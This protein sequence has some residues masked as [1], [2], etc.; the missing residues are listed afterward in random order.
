MKILTL[1]STSYPIASDGSEA[2]GSFVADLVLTLA[3]HVMVRV[4]APGPQTN[5]EVVNERVTVYRFSAPNKPLSTL[6]PWNLNDVL[7]TQRVLRGGMQATHQ[8]AAG[9]HH[10]FALWALPAGEWARRAAKKNNIDYSVWMLGSDIWSLGKIPFLR[11]FLKT[12]ICQS[13]KAYADGIIL[14]QD[15]EKISGRTIDFLPSTRAINLCNPGAPHDQAP[16]RLLFL[17]RWHPNKGIDLLLEALKL[18]NDDDWQAIES[19]EIQ[20]GGPMQALVQNEVNQLQASGRPVILGSYLAKEA[21][22]QAI[23]RA[24]WVLIPSRIESI[25]VVFSDAMKLKRPVLAMPVGDLPTLIHNS[26]CGLLARSVS[27]NDYALALQTILKS[28][29]NEFAIGVNLQAENFDLEK[30]AV[31]I[32]REAMLHDQ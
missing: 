19:I 14:A 1:I 8:A 30:L 11:L 21:A 9:S 32:L 4:V 6:K 7:W 25:P 2:A 23:V 18:L 29:T 26:H 10:I 17:G 27:A 28:K 12:V 22:E 13:K 24:D 3:K 5:L 31:T 16:Y 20:G 15:A